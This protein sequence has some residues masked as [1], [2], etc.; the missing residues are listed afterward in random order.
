MVLF[1]KIL[2]LILFGKLYQ[3]WKWS[4]IVNIIKFHKSLKLFFLMHEM[5]FYQ[6]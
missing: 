3:R 2:T 5:I 6:F 1:W 4:R